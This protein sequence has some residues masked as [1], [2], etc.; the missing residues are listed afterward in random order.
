MKSIQMKVAM[1]SNFL[2][3][4]KI[5][6]L[7]GKGHK[8]EETKPA[9]SGKCS[10]QAGGLCGEEEMIDDHSVNFVGCNFRN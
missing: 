2:N 4:M 10:T 3:F 1:F 5:S 6:D 7:K 9:P 8:A